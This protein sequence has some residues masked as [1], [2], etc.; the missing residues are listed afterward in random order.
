M[1]LPTI[2]RIIIMILTRFILDIFI[3]TININHVDKIEIQINGTMFTINVC[4]LVLN[5][6]T[7][8]FIETTSKNIP[9]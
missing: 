5:I 8:Y 7:D 4:P 3:K 1:I 9:I 6:T 2:I